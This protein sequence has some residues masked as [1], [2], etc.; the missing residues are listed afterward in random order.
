M[1]IHQKICSEY[2][3]TKYLDSD[4]NIFSSCSLGSLHMVQEA[5]R[6]GESPG[7]RY[8]TQFWESGWTPIRFA[9]LSGSKNDKGVSHD[10]NLERIKS[11]IKY[12]VSMGA[13]INSQ[14]DCGVTTLMSVAQ[15]KRRAS[16]VQLLVT[17]GA[18][19]SIKDHDNKTVFDYA[20]SEPIRRIIE[21]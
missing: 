18:D 9:A 1:T 2:E 11:I 17:L 10:L 4:M 12:L 5:V 21:M 6:T 3:M 20:S 16:I 14:D 19:T 8:E 13:D 15:F 7:V